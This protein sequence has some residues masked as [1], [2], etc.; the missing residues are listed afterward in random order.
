MSPPPADVPSQVRL[1][2]LQAVMLLMPD[3]H[4]EALWTLLL[5]LKE[6]SAHSE[7]NQVRPMTSVTSVTIRVDLLRSQ[8]MAGVHLF[9]GAYF[10]FQ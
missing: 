1:Q 3:E 6:V 2:A 10:N 9:L 7:T 8:L 4:R 5:F